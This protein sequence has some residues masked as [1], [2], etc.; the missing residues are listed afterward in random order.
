M[1]PLTFWGRIAISVFE[2]KTTIHLLKYEE[3]SA[4]FST[5]FYDLLFLGV[6][7]LSIFLGV[8]PIE[9]QINII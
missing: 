1:F 3:C 6:R 9:E 4:P 8:L 7:V 2:L 5:I